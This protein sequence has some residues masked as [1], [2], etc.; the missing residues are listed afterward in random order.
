[1]RDSSRREAMVEQ[2]VGDAAGAT[3]GWAEVRSKI[4]VLI[5]HAGAQQLEEVVVDLP[6][7]TLER[8]FDVL[9]GGGSA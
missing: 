5:G 7:S 9:E 8:L 6:G 4:A 3:F 2:P 1:M